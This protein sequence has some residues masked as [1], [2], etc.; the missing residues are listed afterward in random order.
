MRTGECYVCPLGEISYGPNT[1]VS[2]Q[3]FQERASCL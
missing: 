2:P 1:P 3:E